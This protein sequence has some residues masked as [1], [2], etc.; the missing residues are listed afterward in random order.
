MLQ[1]VYK[2]RKIVNISTLEFFNYISS[3]VVN[4]LVSEENE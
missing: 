1:K 4:I 3:S 2:K